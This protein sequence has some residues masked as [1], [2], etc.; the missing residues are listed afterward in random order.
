MNKGTIGWKVINSIA[1]LNAKWL[2]AMAST[3]AGFYDTGN[4]IE[5]YFEPLTGLIKEWRGNCASCGFILEAQDKFC[6]GCGANIEASE[7]TS[8]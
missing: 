8:E 3:D 2:N 5:D 4:P 6:G 1:N 7:L